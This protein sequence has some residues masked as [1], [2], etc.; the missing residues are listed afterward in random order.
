MSKYAH[1]VQT[2]DKTRVW[3]MSNK[4]V[5]N[6]GRWKGR[7]LF[8]RRSR[9]S[10]TSAPVPIADLVRGFEGNWVA[11]KDGDVVA[12]RP[13]PDALHMEIRGT[14]KADALI[15]RVPD[16]DEPELVGFG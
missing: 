15:L 1:V 5:V 2:R 6:V 8:G 7:G 10:P 4:G 12:A 3:I 14:D 9:L 11:I 16:H 13:T